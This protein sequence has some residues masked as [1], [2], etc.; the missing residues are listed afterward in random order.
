LLLLALTTVPAI[1]PAVEVTAC[2]IP[3]PSSMTS[4][5][6]V[7]DL[8]SKINF[9]PFASSKIKLVGSYSS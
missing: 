4:P 3:L 8:S 9:L 5:K 6:V 1:A 2:V 7:F